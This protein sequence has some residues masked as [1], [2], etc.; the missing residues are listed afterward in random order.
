MISLAFHPD[1]DV[2]NGHAHTVRARIADTCIG[3]GASNILSSTSVE[4]NISNFV[5]RDMLRLAG[6]GQKSAKIL[7]ANSEFL[8]YLLIAGYL[9]DLNGP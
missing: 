1:V 3:P 4:R 9:H 5:F 2:G 8:A 6:G 7:P